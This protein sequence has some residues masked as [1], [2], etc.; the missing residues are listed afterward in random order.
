MVQIPE[1]NIEEAITGPVIAD[2]LT[3]HRLAL[4]AIEETVALTLAAVEV[5]R[6]K[7]IGVAVALGFGQLVV[8]FHAYRW[9]KQARLDTENQ[10]YLNSR[11]FRT[12]LD[13]I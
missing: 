7:P 5:V 11:P 2:E 13:D 12:E 1:N 4:V 10:A 9:K 8:G 3:R 6:S